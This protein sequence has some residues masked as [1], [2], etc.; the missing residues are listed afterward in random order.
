MRTDRTGSTSLTNRI[1]QEEEEEKEVC[2]FL[3]LNG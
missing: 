1:V 3:K 2:Y